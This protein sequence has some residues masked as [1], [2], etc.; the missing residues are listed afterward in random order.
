MGG[1]LGGHAKLTIQERQ[2]HLQRHRS[3]P[4]WR[5]GRQLPLQRLLITG[6]GTKNGRRTRSASVGTL[7]NPLK[8]RR[9]TCEGNE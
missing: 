7:T 5:R 3:L 1:L 6:L 8:Q 9:R 2:R 4:A